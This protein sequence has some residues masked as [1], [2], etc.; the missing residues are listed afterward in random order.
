MCMFFCFLTVNNPELHT[1]VLGQVFPGSK[2]LH[3]AHARPRAAHVQ[4]LSALVET[5][6]HKDDVAGT[7]AQEFDQVQ[8]RF[9]KWNF[10]P[11]KFDA[12]MKY[13][14]ARPNAL[15]CARAHTHTRTHTHTHIH[16][17]THTTHTNT[18]TKTHTPRRG[19]TFL[20]TPGHL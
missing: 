20:K 9:C 12:S 2:Y 17:H 5:A 8:V 13:C 18:H 16:T 19:T 11:K 15:S 6:R 4:A 7:P 14:T 1:Q 10:H 3:S